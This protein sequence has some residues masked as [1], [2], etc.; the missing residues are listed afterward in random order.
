MEER[1]Y[2]IPPSDAL[3]DPISDEECTSL[4]NNTGLSPSDNENSCDALNNRLLSLLSQ[5][6][7][8]ISSGNMVIFP[9]EDSKCDEEDDNPTL[10]SILSRIYRICQAFSCII[11]EFDPALA[12]MLLSGTYPQVLMGSPNAGSYPIWVNPD[13][14]VTSGS[15]RPVTSG[16]VY[17]A[18][19]KALTQVWHM[20]SAHPVFQ[21]YADSLD[22][23]N[24]QD[25]SAV[26][27]GDIAMILKPQSSGITYNQIF[28]YTD[29]EWVGG[30]IYGPFDKDTPDS[31]ENFAVI[32]V[33]K[34]KW[35]D[36]G[37]YY[38]SVPYNYD[39]C[40]WN[41]LDADPYELE[42]L[43]KEV[44]DK[45]ENA[46]VPVD[47]VQYEVGVVDTLDEANAIQPEAGKTKLIF[48][49]GS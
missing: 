6:L 45:Y 43:V 35:A 44:T 32:H 42:Q 20:W 34:G 30:Q 37:L 22:D 5:V 14:T 12:N 24:S 25:L 7:G 13:T 33:E 16:A 41:V 38:Y 21:Y 29:G 36:N 47:D 46:V 28:T 27:E 15:Q 39:T 49:V 23:L 17:T 9:N 18:V 1:E 19:Q 11:C 2:N 8:D 48:I 3:V 26:E 10:A 4:A 31:I 40:S